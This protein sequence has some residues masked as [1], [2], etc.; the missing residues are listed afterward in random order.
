[1]RRP[2]YKFSR[3]VD[4]YCDECQ[5]DLTGLMDHYCPCSHDEARRGDHNCA[6]DHI[7]PLG[8]DHWC[9]CPHTL[10]ISFISEKLSDEIDVD[11]R[12][13]VAKVLAKDSTEI[14]KWL[15]SNHD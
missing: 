5:H 4:H 9:P 11:A 1:M 8:D 7:V 6:C 15:S 14:E 3:Y 10:S 12:K 2:A 13:R